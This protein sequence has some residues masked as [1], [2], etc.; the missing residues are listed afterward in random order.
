[1]RASMNT[2]DMINEYGDDCSDIRRKLVVDFD[3]LSLL[4]GTKD[5]MRHVST[6]VMIKKLV[7]ELVLHLS[8]A[9]DLIP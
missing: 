1:M 9:R 8:Y 2:E 6:S 7:S 4:K 5:K 3:I